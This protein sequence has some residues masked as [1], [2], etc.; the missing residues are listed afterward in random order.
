MPNAI[1]TSIALLV[2]LA[3]PGLL[4]GQGVEKQLMQ[5]ENECTAANTKRDAAA[6]RRIIAKDYIGTELRTTLVQM[7]TERSS[8]GN[9]T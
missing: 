2:I 4:V 7:K 8:I 5:L 3:L 6:L 1:R 9:R